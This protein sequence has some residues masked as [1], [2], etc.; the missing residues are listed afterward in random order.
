MPAQALEEKLDAL[1]AAPGVYLMKDRRG[2]V[3]YVGKAVNLRNRVRSYFTR[4]GDTRAFVPLL[5]SLL[6]DVETVLVQQREGG[7][8]PRER[9]DQE[10]QAA[11]QRPAQGR[12]EVH[13]PAAG[14]AQPY[15]R[16]E[17]V[18]RFRRDGARYFGPVL[19][20]ER[21]PRDAA[22]HQPLL[23]AAHLLG[24]RAAPTAG[25]PACCTRSAA[26]RRP[27]VY[28]VPREEYARAWTRWRCSWR[29]RR[30]ELVEAL[31]ARMKAAPPASSS[32]RR[33]RGC[34][35]SSSPSSAAWSGRR[36][37]PPRPSTRTCSASTARRDRL[38]VLRPLRAP[39]PA[40]RRPGLPLQRPG[41]PR[42]GAARV[43]SST[44]TTTRTTSCPRRCCCRC[45][46]EGGEG[47]E[48]LLTETQGRAGAGA[49][50]PARREGATWWRWRRR[51]P[52]RPSSSASAAKDET[53]AVL[54]R[55]QQRLHLRDLPRRME[56][57]DIS[58]FQGS[59]IVASPGGGHRRR[60]RTSRAT[61]A[62]RSR[63]SE[64][65]DDFASMY[66]V[67][68]RR[69]KRGLDETA[70]CRTCSSSTAARA[71]S[72]ARTRR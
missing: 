64:Q 53:E 1:P 59:S 23:P 40:Q 61:A 50:A 44:S 68:T 19:E 15:P 49:G 70:T 55:L 72:P 47:L 26:A 8:A 42:R 35:T 12:Q 54:E 31:R 66:E 27:C 48:E 36:S 58:H 7:A 21:H 33:P 67:L 17:V 38:L 39:G 56:C 30:G 25:G 24:P 60:D 69:L 37:R 52:S 11:L 62:T 20:R 13:L 29:A 28:D 3:I 16:L 2:E 65:Q 71:S 43:A 10:A 22:D 46:P 14:P 57:F 45:E 6:G 18:R 5:D 63:R 32:S 4:T 9:A 41:V 51:T 34:A